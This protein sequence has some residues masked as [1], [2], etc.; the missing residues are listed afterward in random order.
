MTVKTYY[1]IKSWKYVQSRCPDLHHSPPDD[2]GNHHRNT[3]RNANDGSGGFTNTGNH[4]E[5]SG[6]IKQ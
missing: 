6:I 2:D 4:N 5:Q 3:P 1:L